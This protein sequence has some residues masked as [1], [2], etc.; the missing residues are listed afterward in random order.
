MMI[1]SDL[2][3]A[4]IRLVVNLKQPCWPGLYK[5]HELFQILIC[6]KH[7]STNENRE[8]K[9]SGSSR[10]REISKEKTFLWYTHKKN[11]SSRT[12]N[13]HCF[14]IG[15]SSTTSSAQF[16]TVQRVFGT[17]STFSTF[18]TFEPIDKLGQLAR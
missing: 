5:L 1:H 4:V 9:M 6:V 13:F 16:H 8:A 2:P 18:S 15:C 3:I 17:F 12:T 11:P 14:K 7:M 10:K